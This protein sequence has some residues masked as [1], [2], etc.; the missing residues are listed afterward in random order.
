MW[1]QPK[2][3]W[4]S[5]DFFNIEDYNRIKGNLNEIRLLSCGRIL[6]LRIW[7]RTRPIL[8]MVFMRMR[9]IGSKS[10]WTISAMG[11]FLL[12]LAREKLFTKTNLSLT[13]KS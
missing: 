12:L 13:G 5:S 7:G 10:M 6:N 9:L 3:D 1:Q 2:T 4:Q 8:I 11:Y